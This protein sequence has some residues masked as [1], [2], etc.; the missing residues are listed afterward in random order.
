AW[1]FRHAIVIHYST[2][3]WPRRL[4]SEVKI[5]HEMFGD[6]G[7]SIPNWILNSTITR[8]P[9]NNFVALRERV[10]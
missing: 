4:K 2:A 6:P 1:H 5:T 10:E 3:R 8:A 9:Y 7:G